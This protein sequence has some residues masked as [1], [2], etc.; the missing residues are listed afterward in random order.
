M[1][2]AIQPRR[3]PTRRGLGDRDAVRPV[4]CRVPVRVDAVAPLALVVLVEAVDPVPVPVRDDLDDAEP[5]PEPVLDELVLEV[6]VEVFVEVLVE[7][8]P[9]SVD[10]RDPPVAEPPDP[11]SP[12]PELDVR[13]PPPVAPER[14]RL[15]AV[16]VPPVPRP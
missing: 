7:E 16:P 3:S 6:F 12:V 13:E 5:D 15:V 1:I 11:S 4:D 14:V 2:A 8:D 9:V 10:L